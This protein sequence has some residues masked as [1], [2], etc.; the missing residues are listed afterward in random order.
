VDITAAYDILGFMTK[1][2]NFNM[3]SILNG[4]GGMVISK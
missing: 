3:S 2:I 4:C 1:K